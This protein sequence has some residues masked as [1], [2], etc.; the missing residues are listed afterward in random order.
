MVEKHLHFFVMY[1]N[2]M[3]L[4]CQVI[5]IVIINVPDKTLC[6]QRTN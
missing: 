3:A 5:Y 2:K 1:S 4:T 6:Q